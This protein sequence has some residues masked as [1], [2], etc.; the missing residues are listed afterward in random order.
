MEKSLKEFIGEKY[1][2]IQLILVNIYS[3]VLWIFLIKFDLEKRILSYSPNWYNYNYAKDVELLG[4]KIISLKALYYIGFFALMLILVL[5]N[6]RHIVKVNRKKEYS[7]EEIRK[8]SLI[9]SLIFLVLLIF[10]LGR[11]ISIEIALF[12][13]LHSLYPYLLFKDQI[14]DKKIGITLENS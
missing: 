13:L 9:V 1:F 11:N 8:T 4:A 10:A 2:T 5:L 14:A 12:Q 6:D 7:N 3:L